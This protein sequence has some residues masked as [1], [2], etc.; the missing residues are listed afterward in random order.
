VAIPVFGVSSD[1]Q[2]QEVG[3]FGDFGEFP[4]KCPIGIHGGLESHPICS[5][6]HRV[7]MTVPESETIIDIN[8]NGRGG[9]L[10]RG[11]VSCI[12]QIPK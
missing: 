6:T 11:M 4:F 1:I 7:I 3:S 9:W 12:P 8:G 5:V 10:Q 2:V